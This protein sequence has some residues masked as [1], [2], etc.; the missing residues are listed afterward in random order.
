MEGGRGMEGGRM[1][2]EGGRKSGGTLG[3][4]AAGRP[5]SEEEEVG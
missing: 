1:S 3:H 4:G 5:D 2:W